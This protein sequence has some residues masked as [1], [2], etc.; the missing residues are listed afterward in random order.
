MRL[1]AGRAHFSGD[2]LRAGFDQIRD[3]CDPAAPA[4]LEGDRSADPRACV[5]DQRDLAGKI[6]IP[7]KGGG[8]TI[9]HARSP[10]VAKASAAE[11]AGINVSDACVDTLWESFELRRFQAPATSS[12]SCF[13]FASRRRATR[14]SRLRQRNRRNIARMS[15]ARASGASYGS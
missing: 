15:C 9:G 3:H 2:T 13:V 12:A 6:A 11:F 5:D 8:I 10:S 14:A 4:P 7:S 1:P